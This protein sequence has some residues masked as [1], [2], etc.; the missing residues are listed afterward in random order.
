MNSIKYFLRKPL[1]LPLVILQKVGFF[2]F[3]KRTQLNNDPITF[4]IWFFQKVLGYNRQAYWPVHK[5]SRVVGA[6][7]IFVGVGSNP[8]YNPG[9]YIQGTGKLKIGNY[10]TFGQNTGVLSGGHDV[11]DHRVLTKG[12]TTIGDYC[13]IGMNSV[14][15]PNVKLGDFTVVASGSVVTK[16]FPDGYCVIGG[17]PAKFIKY[18]NK[19][20]AIKFQYKEKFHGYLSEKQYQER[21]K[22][23]ERSNT[24]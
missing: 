23:L 13:W 22:N 17:V 7:N 5:S 14:I 12:E 20:K 10:T 24:K 11:Y 16:S 3:I 19:D 2:K 21:L 9:C 4:S 15:L 6:H 18:L 1:Q 8:G